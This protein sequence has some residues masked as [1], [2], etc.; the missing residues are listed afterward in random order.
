MVAEDGGTGRRA[1]VQCTGLWAQ[2]HG[3]GREPTPYCHPL[4]V[5]A[6]V[7]ASVAGPPRVAQ[8][9]AVAV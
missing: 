7:C 6:G 1:S 9:G 8:V 5:L 4:L 3:G 2:A